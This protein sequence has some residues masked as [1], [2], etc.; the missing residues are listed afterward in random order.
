MAE[1]KVSIVVPVYNAERH[2]L[3]CLASLQTQS[4]SDIEVVLVMMALQTAA[5]S[6]SSEW[7]KKIPAFV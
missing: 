4:L 3:R 5:W 1:P 6:C 7:R 2:L